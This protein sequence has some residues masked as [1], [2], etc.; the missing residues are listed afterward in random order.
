MSASLAFK[1]STVS[2]GRSGGGD[3]C[4]LCATSSLA[5]CR[6]G[7]PMICRILQVI[8]SLRGP[9]GLLLAV[10]L[11]LRLDRSVGLLVPPSL[12]GTS[13][14]FLVVGVDGSLFR[15]TGFISNQTK[16]IQCERI[17]KKR[18]E[19]GA[20]KDSTLSLTFALALPSAKP[21]PFCSK[22]G[23]VTGYIFFMPEAARA[24]VTSPTHKEKVCMFITRWGCGDRGYNHVDLATGLI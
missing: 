21:Y 11:L 2:S 16:K 17:W 12:L 10:M 8:F 22:L 13:F 9:T 20:Q 6:H 1:S 14:E 19:S 18:I 15:F 3:V 23:T 5:F 7:N 4:R 24:L